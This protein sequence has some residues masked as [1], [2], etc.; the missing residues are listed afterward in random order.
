MALISCPE[1]SREISDKA[2][3]C[4]QC[5]APSANPTTEAQFNPDTGQRI[6]TE[7][8]GKSN[9]TQV[10]GNVHNVRSGGAW[11]A[12][13]FIAI[14]VGLIMAMASSG[15]MG[16]GGLLMLVGFV[17]FLAGRFM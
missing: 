4:P 1:C 16:F 12:L 2:S 6:A 14:V 9:S 3:V 17:V 5:G 15:M 10:T 8:S 11:E 7:R 13:G